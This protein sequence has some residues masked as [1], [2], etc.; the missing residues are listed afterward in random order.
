MAYSGST[1]AIL[2]NY[3]YVLKKFYLPAIREQI[4]N[5]TVLMRRLKRNQESVSGK[6]ATIA[7]HYGRNLGSIALGDG[8]LLPDAGYQQVIE[9]IVPMKYNYGRIT[10]S[11]PTIAASRDAKGAYAKAIDYEMKGLIK[12]VSK[13]CNRQF[14][15]SGYGV[16]A[17]YDTGGDTATSF[18]CQ[19]K[20]LGTGGAGFGSGFGSKYVMPEGQTGLECVA[21]VITAGTS[22]TVDATPLAPSAVT[23]AST[24]DDVTVTDPSVSEAAGTVIIKGNA[25]RAVC[26]SGDSDTEID[27]KEMMGIWGIVNNEDPVNVFTSDGATKGVTGENGLQSL[28]EGTYDWWKASV[29]SHAAGRYQA[30]RALTTD[31]MQ[32]AVDA[33][34]AQLADDMG[35]AQSPTI[36]LTTRAIRRKYVDL[37]VQDKRFVDW[38][39]MDGGYKVIEFNGI[40]IAVDNDAIDGE[41]YFL[42]EPSMQIY[43]MSDLS[44]ME[45]DGNVLDRLLGY[46]AY[47]ATLFWYAE[48]GCSRRNVNAVLTDLSY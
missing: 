46:D 42:Y 38:K 22:I 12:D 39:V 29:L 7:V 11:G 33:V 14:W 41:M 9:T 8:G 34:E 20:Y 19:K 25:T 6:N 32:E 18:F 44:W 2:S 16:L 23:K 36:I 26:S 4:N 21:V 30:Q 31:L 35:G 17:R 43:Q 3:S 10:V 27:R 47:E 45:R 37:L 28:A 24:Y 5:A 40:P 1:A 15:G 48:L 13:D